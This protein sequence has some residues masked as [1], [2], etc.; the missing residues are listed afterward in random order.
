LNRTTPRNLICAILLLVVLATACDTTVVTV[1]Q[2]PPSF[3]LVGSE[4]T[5]APPTEAP[6]TPLPTRD[7]EAVQ[8]IAIPLGFG[9]QKGFWQVLFTAPTGSRDASTYVGGL[10]IV[11]A[12]AI[13]N[14]RRTLDIAAFEFNNPV[15][16]KAVLDA[17]V[18]GV[19]VRMVTDDEHGFN[20]KESTVPQ[21]VAA[22]IP[23]TTDGRS[24]LMHDKFMILDSQVVWTGSW[25]YTIND[26]YRN[27]NNAIAIR[28]Q[29]FVQ[30][31]QT[32]FDEMFLRNQFGLWPD[33]TIQYTFRQSDSERYTHSGLLWL[34][35][36]SESGHLRRAQ[37]GAALNRLYGLLVYL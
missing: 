3:T 33:L 16:T 9:A 13:N 6:L 32:E 36:Q 21:L 31:Y 24:A 18:R 23:V 15:L 20:D 12:R 26:T 14:T 22:G 37:S 34:G 17:R 8:D 28:S 2:L 29:K 7:T 25:N 35:R 27:N 10:D 11:L 5:T 4:P 30:D 19:V 1:T